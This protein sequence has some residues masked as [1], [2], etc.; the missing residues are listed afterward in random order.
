MTRIEAVVRVLWQSGETHHTPLAQ[1]A[2]AEPAD[3]EKMQKKT[4]MK[5]GLLS[6]LLS[7]TICASLTAQVARAPMVSKRESAVANKVAGCYEL[8]RDG[9]QADSDLVMFGDIPRN[10][11]RFELTKNIAR[12]WDPLAA[13]MH[14]TYFTVRIDSIRYWGRE[15]GFTTWFLLSNT[16]STIRVVGS[17]VALAGFGLT[18]APHDSDL[19]G[20]IYGFTDAVS[21]GAKSSASHAVTAR[22]VSCPVVR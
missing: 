11:V 5:A 18:L 7:H 19:V 15:L 14:V 13:Y 2:A 20:T 21:P 3:G 22:R 4:L 10:P 1:R 17:P 6:F 12:A 9:W 16:G 8:L